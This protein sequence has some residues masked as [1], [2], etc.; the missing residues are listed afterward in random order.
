MRFEPELKLAITAARAA[1]ELL[2]GLNPRHVDSQEGRDIK[3]RA[4]R[5]SEALILECLNPSGLPVLSEECGERGTYTGGLR[6]IVDPLDGSFNFFKGLPELCCT[7]IA[8]WDDETPVLGVVYRFHLEEMLTGLVGN[9][10]CRNDS[11]ISPSTV[12]TMEHACCATG[13]SVKGDFSRERLERYLSLLSRAK[14]VR[15][16][17]TAAI[18]SSSVAC[19]RVDLYHEED[20]LLWDVAAGMAL[21]RAAGGVTE[22]KAKADFKCDAACFANEALRKAFHLAVDRRGAHGIF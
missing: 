14:K 18:M 13:L 12:T 7:S 4:D 6:W 16:L 19:G 3:L 11:P 10:A 2:K 1:G 5:E 22:Y 8:L 15:M 21:V 17:G 9:G 20:I